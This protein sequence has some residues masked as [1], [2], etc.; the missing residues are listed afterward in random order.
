VLDFFTVEEFRAANQRRVERAGGQKHRRLTEFDDEILRR[1]Q[2]TLGVPALEVLHPSLMYNLFVRFWRGQA[3]LELIDEHT[4]FRPFRPPPGAADLGLPA[5]YVAVKFY[6]SN[7]FPATLEN[8]ALVSRIVR[9]L[10]AQSQVVLLD[11]GLVID[12]HRDS[13]P[14]LGER[15]HRL[16]SHVDPARNLELQSR[17]VAGARA[18]LGTYG[19]FSYL[20][21]SY[22][23][24]SLAIYSDAGGF[25]PIHLRV[26]ERA[27]NGP[28]FGAL[29]IAEAAQVGDVSWLWT[30]SGLRAAV[31]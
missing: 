19:G 9:A 3:G 31:V 23:V 28:P 22:G 18:F 7:C 16:P 6:W 15:I 25:L 24:P 2:R 26:A 8:R 10:A 20:G 29:R 30:E 13:E 27:F 1:V 5:D 14:P 21:P 11:T 4:R 12:D 17:V